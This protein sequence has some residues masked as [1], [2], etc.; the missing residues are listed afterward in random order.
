MLQQFLQ[1]FSRESASN[2]P[3]LALHLFSDKARILTATKAKKSW[4]LSA[5][6]H[7]LG[8]APFPDNLQ[9]ILAAQVKAKQVAVVLAPELYQIV[10]LDKPNLP[11][12][13]EILQ[14]LPWLIKDLCTLAP[15]DMQVDYI[16]L[17]NTSAAVAKIN[18]VVA[19]QAMLKPLCALLQHAKL[20]PISIVPEEWLSLQLL[21]TAG[22][23]QMI[24]QQQAGHD[25]ILQVVRDGQLCFNRHL[26]GFKVLP[27]MPLA[28]IASGL[29]DNLLLE[30]QR[31]MDFV[32]AQLKLPPVREVVLLLDHP[33]LPAIAGLFQQAG[34]NQAQ[35]AALPAHWSWAATLDVPLYWP[36]IVAMAGLMQAS[37]VVLE[38]AG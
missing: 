29:F 30:V 20:T 3:L 31:S 9:K 35:L 13:A 37:E 27:Q 28:Q 32:E 2:G 15:E 16:D 10:P 11:S 36:A 7:T 4:H 25:L 6:E 34:F 33:E 8:A 21:P 14:A 19:S 1:K 23:T 17:A 22:P 5:T 12:S 18:V 38:T 24:L 26:R